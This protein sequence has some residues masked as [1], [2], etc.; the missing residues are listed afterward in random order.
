MSGQVRACE[1]KSEV[2]VPVKDK[3]AGIVRNGDTMRAELDTPARNEAARV[4]G[5]AV[6]AELEPT[7]GRRVFLTSHCPRG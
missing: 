7:D 5:N 4:G 2:T 1:H 3:I 6:V